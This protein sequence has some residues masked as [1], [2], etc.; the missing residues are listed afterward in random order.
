MIR[1]AY[2][3]SIYFEQQFSLLLNY[4]NY[5]KAVYHRNLHDLWSSPYYKVFMVTVTIYNVHQHKIARGNFW[6]V[7][8]TTSN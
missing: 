2:T 1:E 6:L 3:D 7:S 8:K 4:N 5:F